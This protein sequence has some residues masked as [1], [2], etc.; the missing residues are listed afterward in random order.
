MTSFDDAGGDP[1]AAHHGA[2]EL[3]RLTPLSRPMAWDLAPGVVELPDGARIR[4][5]GLREGG[6]S[7]PYPEWGLYLVG[8][9]P[10]DCPWPFR[11]LR[12]PDFWLPRSAQEARSLFAQAH[13]LA[14]NGRRVE[15]A[16][17]GGIGRTG[18]ALACIAQLAGVTAEDATAW[19]RRHYNPRAVETP[20]Q[21]RYVRRFAQS[22]ASR[23]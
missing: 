11:W 17:D 10:G 4:G 19:V 20:W 3:R 21:R 7:E 8:K 15:V 1:C 12:W 13:R 16:C 9:R 2:H 14:I 23:S 6:P 22:R 18:T 5:R